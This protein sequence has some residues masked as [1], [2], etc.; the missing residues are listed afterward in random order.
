MYSLMH[1]SHSIVDFIRLANRELYKIVVL[2]Q[3]HNLMLS[4]WF[5]QQS[6]YYNT[7]LAVRK[8]IEHI[9]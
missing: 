4:C 3:C 5:R 2:Y 6:Q 8:V 9:V 1:R 7:W